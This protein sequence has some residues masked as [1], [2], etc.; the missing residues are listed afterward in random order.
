MK[1]AFI[2]AALAAIIFGIPASAFAADYPDKWAGK[3]TSKETNFVTVK[4]LSFTKEKDGSVKVRGA[5]VGFP[6]EVSIG[7][8]TLEAYADRNNKTTPDVFVASFSSNRFKPFLIM[9]G[10][11]SSQNHIDTISFQCFTTDADGSKIH[12]NGQLQREE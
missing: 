7:E 11:G 4:R 12:V 2:S 1:G 5:L 6:D 9:T 3:F 8:A 10:Y